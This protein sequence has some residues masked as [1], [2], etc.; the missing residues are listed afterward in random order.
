MWIT[1]YNSASIE[2]DGHCSIKFFVVVIIVVIIVVFIHLCDIHLIQKNLRP[3]GKTHG[4]FERNIHKEE[5][6][7]FV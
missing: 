6:L 5:K 4:K 1:G 7:F 2:T 3:E